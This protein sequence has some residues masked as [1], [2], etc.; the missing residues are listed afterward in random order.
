MPTLLSARNL[1]KAYPSNILFEG[2][3]IHVEDGERIGLIGP[4]GSGKTTLLKI[5]SGSLQPDSGEIVQKRALRVVYV[6]QDDRFADDA[7]PLDVVRAGIDDDDSGM[8]TTTRASIALSKLGF[9]DLQRSVATLS[10]GWRKRLSLASALAKDPDVLML[11]EPTNHLDLE[12]VL[13]LENFVRQVS[14]AIIFVTHDRQF[15]ENTATRIIE[16]SKAYPGG[17]FEATGNYTEFIKRKDAFLDAQRAAQTSIASRVR[18]DT[19]WLQQGIQGRQT[20]N[21]TQVVAAASRRDE[22]KTTTDRNQAPSRTASFAFHS[23]QRKT[24][25]L[26]ALQ[27]VAKSMGDKQLFESLDL[28]LTPGQRIGLLG[29]NGSGKT[30]LMRLMSGDLD[31][32]SGNIKR[33]D[34]LQ[35]VTFSQHRESLNQNQTLQEAL[36]PYGETVHYHGHSIHVS[37]WARRFLFDADQLSTRISNLSGGEQA[38]VL[39]ANLTLLP[40]DV[41]LLDEPTNDLDIPSLE[42]LEQAL[43]EFSGAIV[44]VTHDRFLLERIATEYLSLN[45]QGDAKWYASI[46]Q[47]NSARIKAAPPTPEKSKPA[48]PAPKAQTPSKPGKLS[49]M[50]QLE[51]DGM[52]EAILKAETQVEHLET[53]AADPALS[54]DHKRAATVYSNLKDGQSR[55]ADLYARWAQLDA[56]KNSG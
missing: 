4:N 35:I 39:I 24:K 43:L 5:L 55:V 33:A 42:V 9:S 49:Y 30:T 25:K 10:G 29:V 21:K 18:R 6:D 32:D 41:L 31:P 34:N 12:G 7:T 50:L 48:Q 56:M 11:D 19:A 23:T 8:D 2:V 22:L 15:L 3:S 46:Q 17:S 14:I 40:A 52:E 44:L 26:L 36:C 13:W 45:D 16:L 53:E 51:Y 54:S 1:M 37:G 38:R 27:S 47:W 20:R 28:T